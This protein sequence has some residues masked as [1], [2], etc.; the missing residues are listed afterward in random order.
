MEGKLAVD[1]RVGDLAY[2]AREVYL[3]GMQRLRKDCYST[4]WAYRE[5]REGEGAIE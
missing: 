1:Y 4:S 2:K 3:D 5:I